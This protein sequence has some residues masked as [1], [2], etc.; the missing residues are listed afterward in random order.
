M[1]RDVNL[2][3]PNLPLAMF[4]MLDNQARCLRG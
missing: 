2:D 3:Y 1:G 4:T